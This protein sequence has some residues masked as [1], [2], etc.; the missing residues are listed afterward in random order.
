[1]KRGWAA[2]HRWELFLMA[3]LVV[4]IV[5]NASLSP[6][7]LGVNNFVNLF[8]L[9]N[10]KIIV[11]IIMTYV[12]ISGEID[13][14][15]ASV[16]GF[17]AAVMA[18]VHQDSSFPFIIAI[19][20]GLTAG[21]LAGLLQGLVITRFGLP[22]LV[23]TL[24]GLIGFRGAARVLMEDQSVSGFPGWFNQLGQQ[25]LLGPLRLALIIFFVGLVI[26]WVVLEKGAFGRKVYVIGNNPEVARFSGVAVESVK[27]R[28]FITSGLVAGFAGVFFAARLGSVRGSLAEFF[29]LDIITMVLLGGVSIFGGSGS[30]LGV[31][32]A[33]FTVLNIRNGLG[34]ANVDGI[35]QTGAIGLLL[36]GSVLV[37]N[38]ARRLS[39]GSSRTQ[40]TASAPP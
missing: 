3:I 8:W 12:I 11:A 37:P 34:L 4:T 13:L 17:S 23:V 7:Y 22:S 9:S 26:A 36:I 20:I 2:S 16:M 6:F 14:S 33:I 18:T 25:T 5:V 24:A 1:M 38:L 21:A 32:L 15:V 40:T 30:M 27:L 28:L 10:E 29:E 35:I 31:A 19:L 39:F